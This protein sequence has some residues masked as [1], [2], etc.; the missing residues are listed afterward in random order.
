MVA[1]QEC[2]W[3]AQSIAVLMGRD[4]GWAGLLVGCTVNS[5]LDGEGCWLDRSVGGLHS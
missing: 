1:G 5:C 3:A 4:A 2:W